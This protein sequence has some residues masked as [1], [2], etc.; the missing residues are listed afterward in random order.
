MKRLVTLIATILAA[1]TF[2]AM[3]EQGL[4]E[5]EYMQICAN[6]HG[7]TGQGDGPLAGLLTAEVPALT[8]LAAANDGTFPFLDTL[9][10]IDGRTGVRGHGGNMPIWGDRFEREATDVAGPYG[11]EAMA[12]GRLLSLVYYLESIQ[13]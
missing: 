7:Q 6:C 1:T 13:Q 8:G 4:G 11:A 9:M 10:T 12:R 2:G 5:S 3:A